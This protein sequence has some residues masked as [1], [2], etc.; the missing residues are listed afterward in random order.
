MTR[1]RYA[2]ANLYLFGD[3]VNAKTSLCYD[4]NEDEWT[5]RINRHFKEPDVL[6]GFL[7]AIEDE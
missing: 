6:E 7:E 5:I 4:I 2:S 1:S 3:D